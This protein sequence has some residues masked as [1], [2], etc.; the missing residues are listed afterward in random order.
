MNL[1]LIR[2]SVLICRFKNR[3]LVRFID[4]ECVYVTTRFRKT[5]ENIGGVRVNSA[6]GRRYN[7]LTR[8]KGETCMCLFVR[9]LKKQ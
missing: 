7:Y 8:K 2:R 9:N 1:Y 3:E 5:R 4:Y 6:S